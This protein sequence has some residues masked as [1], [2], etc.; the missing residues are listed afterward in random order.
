M[1][2]SNL[3][4][5]NL[6][7]RLLLAFMAICPVFY[8][9]GLMFG[10]STLRIGQEQFFQLGATVLF[11]VVILENIYISLF[12]LLTVFLYAYYNFPPI[13]GTYLINIFFGAVLYQIAY[14]VVDRQNVAK[15]YN[16]LLWLAVLNIAWM[17]LQFANFEL[18]F[19][20][21]GKG[22][23]SDH[24]GMLGLKAFMGMFFAMCIPFMCRLNPWIAGLFF[25][26]IYYSECAVA[27]VGGLA[28]LGWHI[29]NQNKKAAIAFLCAASLLGA[30]YVYKDSKANMYTNRFSV[31]KESLRDAFKH[32]ILG[33]GLDSFRNVGDLKPFMYFTKDTD[34]ECVKF[35]LHKE[36]QSLVPPKSLP[37]GTNVNP[38]DHPH[39]EYISLLYEFGL[40]GVLIFVLLVRDIK[41]RFLN[42][43]Y[44]IPLIGFFITILIFSLG[45]FPFHVARIGY[46]IPIFL[47]VY[48]KLTEEEI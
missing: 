42:D 11:S 25:I 26:P 13:G 19:V 21:Y 45:Q 24:V 35:Y 44:V 20:E 18:I 8:Y 6:N 7:L 16:V 9:N 46:A 40:F 34:N 37:P 41:R 36:T 22:F 23:N 48:Y 43:E 32:P 14:K 33:W 30:A 2:L 39:N 12:V 15:F 10:K 29:W 1:T 47:G 31:W 5:K 3:S 27:A 17:A 28:A 38:W 4:L